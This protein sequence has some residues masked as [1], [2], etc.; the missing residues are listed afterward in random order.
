MK[1]L[2]KLLSASFF[3]VLL[4]GCAHPISM[5]P[6]LD[7]VK[8]KDLA[9]IDKKVG[10]YI[11]D[12]NKALEVTTPGGGGDKVRY[13][14]YRDIEPGFYKA[15]TETFRDVS[16]I[17]NLS[18]TDEI[19]KSGIALL[20]VPEIKTTSSS[21]SGLT[22][23]PT[24]FSVSLACTITDASGRLVRQ[25]NVSGEG[26]AEFSEFKSN[27]SLSAVRATNDALVKLMAALGSAPE[28]RN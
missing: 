3:L 17:K 13:F 22:W 11:S 21:T 24:Q 6:D 4:V 26:A 7:A 9:Q 23:P 1:S 18:D 8:V 10:F 12:A 20:I 27:F 19:R 16:K 2:F 28:V 25:L 5:R 15:L 14:P